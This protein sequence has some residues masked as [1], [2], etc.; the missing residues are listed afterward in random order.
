MPE[1]GSSPKKQK[2]RDTR[3]AT[4][5]LTKTATPDL[6][7][8]AS[9]HARAP[10]PDW[11]G[12]VQRTQQSPAALQSDDVLA[13]QRAIGNQATIQLLG[14]T[15][16]ASTAASAPIRSSTP[17]SNIIQRDPGNNKGSSKK[18][19]RKRRNAQA[20]QPPPLPDQSQFPINATVMAPGWDRNVSM[21]EVI[22]GGNVQQPQY[23]PNVKQKLG[24]KISGGTKIQATPILDPAMKWRLVFHPA[25]G[26]P[27]FMR[28]EKVKLDK[29]LQSFVSGFKGA[30][31]EAPEEESEESTAGKWA[32]RTGTGIDN[33][34]GANKHLTAPITSAFSSMMD[35]KYQ[36]EREDK[37]GSLSS[38]Q[39]GVTRPGE[40]NDDGEL[41]AELTDF[42]KG[43]TGTTASIGVTNTAL[44]SMAG[45][46]A[47]AREIRVI[48]KAGKAGDWEKFT[49]QAI[50][51]TLDTGAAKAADVAG[52]IA[53]G[54]SGFGKAAG[55]AGVATHAGQVAAVFGS[56]AQG[57][58]SIVSLSKLITDSIAVNKKR[59]LGEA[60]KG[61][62]L[63]IG[64]D[65]LD[66]IKSL[67]ALGGSLVT[68]L[69][70]FLAPFEATKAAASVLGPIASF[71]TIAVSLVSILI[72]SIDVARRTY[73]LVM[74]KLAAR[75]IKKDAEYQKLIQELPSLAQ[76]AGFPELAADPGKYYL[77]D[78]AI[79]RRRAALTG[80]IEE[81]DRLADKQKS[82][83]KLKRKE[84]TRLKE[85][86]HLHDMSS[87]SSTDRQTEID[88]LHEQQGEVEEKKE[89]Q[90]RRTQWREQKRAQKLEKIKRRRL[91][92]RDDSHD[93][94]G[95]NIGQATQ[96]ADAAQQLADPQSLPSP[97]DSSDSQ[98]EESRQITFTN[99]DRKRL[100]ELKSARFGKRDE[101]RLQVLEEYQALEKLREFLTMQEL[102][103]VNNKRFNRQ[104][105][106]VIVKLGNIS[107]DI[108][109]IIGAISSVIV[110]LTGAAAYGAGAAAGLGI[111]IGTGVTSTS[112]K[113]GG[114][115]TLAGAKGW[116]SLKQTGRNRGWKGFNKEKSS[117]LKQERRFRHA[118]A[119]LKMAGS[120]PAFDNS[121][122]EVKNEYKRM[123]R[124]LSVAGVDLGE[125]YKYN[126]NIGQ[127]VKMLMDA[128]AQRDAD[129][130]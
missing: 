64:S 15:R 26:D 24:S 96:Q 9:T 7:S 61:D 57:L 48:Y 66:W 32:K 87:L 56:I 104:I 84:R 124:F 112:I 71:I 47:F 34:A 20:N 79:S 113:L 49:K 19:K 73:H 99:K 130:S 91:G 103:T 10:I 89:L 86:S 115:G 111:S 41:E 114:A 31:D 18:R 83:G 101:R 3:Q 81:H 29:G 62:A 46:V 128:L 69:R 119:L 110:T 117:E 59:K 40:R 14:Q 120:L 116:R 68:T 8:S 93:A 53:T 123:E 92:Q 98:T 75:G 36:K 12:V 65:T 63:T 38:D 21:R 76:A 88:T 94:V 17:L 100:K 11:R 108:V 58:R 122:D 35:V 28:V 109:S 77:L 30:P 1:S 42:G 74:S 105:T 23:T 13:L 55:A 27:G 44:G 67:M 72:E 22:A 95:A 16:A 60:G 37:E 78:D 80:E 121:D 50:A 51:T 33:L 25:T 107:A 82:K 97:A 102:I 2:R 43:L 39:W 70:L 125:F 106:P 129:L 52:G 54:V 85:W 4:T 118:A 127:Q 5:S 45:I 6:A 90:E 126:G